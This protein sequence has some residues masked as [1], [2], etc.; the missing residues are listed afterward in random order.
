MS[1]D[2]ARVAYPLFQEGD[3]GSHPTS[4]LQFVVYKISTD[5]AKKLNKLWHSRLP[6]FG[7][8]YLDSSTCYGLYFGDICYGVAIWG[9][10]TSP[11][12]PQDKSY[13]ELKRMALAPDVPTNTAS[14]FIAIMTKIIRKEIP[15]VR[16][17]ISYQDT[18]VHKGTIYKAS[19]WIIG[20]YH[21]GAA[22]VKSQ[23]RGTNPDNSNKTS[24]SPKI[25]WEKDL[26]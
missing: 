6:N 11:S 8:G 3:G 15:K 24:F 4:P 5:R 14:R 26:R 17:L 25:R 13:F 9:Y 22:T 23:V 7:T 21:K 10:P 16:K 12:L 18:D 20:N 1:G 19:G 2:G